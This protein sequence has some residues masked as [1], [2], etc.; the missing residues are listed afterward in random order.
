MSLCGT[1]T[2]PNRHTHS[3][4]SFSASDGERLYPSFLILSVN[5]KTLSG[6]SSPG[7]IVQGCDSVVVVIHKPANTR[8]VFSYL[9]Q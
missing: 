9:E 8:M 4:E 1:H 5:M 7:L 6:V 2:L 3:Q